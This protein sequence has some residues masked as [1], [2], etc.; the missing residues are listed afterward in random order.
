MKTKEQERTLDAECHEGDPRD[1]VWVERNG[2]SVRPA[3]KSWKDFPW[4]EQPILSIAEIDEILR[5]DR[6]DER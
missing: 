2:M 5:P 3:T 1:W 4:L 6:E